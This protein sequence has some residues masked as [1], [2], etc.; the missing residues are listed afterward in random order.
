MSVTH[1]WTETVREALY[2][3]ALLVREGEN[4]QGLA[5]SRIWLIGSREE[6]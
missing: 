3:N 6:A 5:T 4:V 1:Q 2:I